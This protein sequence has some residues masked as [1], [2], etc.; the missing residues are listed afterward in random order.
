M[1]TH[2]PL[3]RLRGPFALLLAT[4]SSLFSLTTPA[5]LAA[6]PAPRAATV[7][8]VATTTQVEDFVSQVG[9]DRITLLPVLAPDDDPHSYQP[10]ATDARNFA[11]ADVVFA[12]GVGLET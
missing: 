6:T 10:T 9:G 2:T 7:N 3:P 8:V 12:N 1:L 4:C 11:S 5:A